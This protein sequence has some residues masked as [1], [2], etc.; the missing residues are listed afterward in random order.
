MFSWVHLIDLRAGNQ[1]ADGESMNPR[2]MEK[3]G[4]VRINHKWK[5]ISI[6]GIK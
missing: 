2:S 1:E 3:I 6:S 5:C 4:T